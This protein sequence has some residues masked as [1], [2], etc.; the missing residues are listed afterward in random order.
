MNKLIVVTKKKRQKK[1][2]KELRGGGVD[3]YMQSRVQ[4]TEFKPLHRANDSPS[5]PHTAGCVN[6]KTIITQ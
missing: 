3:Q 1:R 6:T 4:L 2:Q 5:A